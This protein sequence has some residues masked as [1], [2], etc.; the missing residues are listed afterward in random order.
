VSDPA[1]PALK[2]WGGAVMIP[3]DNLVFTSWNVNEMTEVEFS[4]LVAEVDETGFDEPVLVIPIPDEPGQYL[5]PSGEHR[6][7]AAHALGMAEIPCV[8][9]AHLI[10]KDEAELKMWSVK[11]NGIRGRINA[12]KYAD[13]E[14]SLWEKNKIRSDVARKRMLVRGETLKRLRKSGGVADN[15]AAE[16]KD[17][18]SGSSSTSSGPITTSDDLADTPTGGAPPTPGPKGPAT[19]GERADRKTVM[20]R[21]QL[22]AALKTAEE[23]VLLQSADSVEHGYLFFVQGAENQMHLVVDES[24][25]LAGLV[26]RMV[27]SCKDESARVDEFLISAITRELK[28]YGEETSC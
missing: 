9:K 20:S 18:A 2:Q 19:D 1:A 3:L 22:L 21:K 4:E 14:R 10:G 15:E 16:A 8:I 27:H 23:E 11:R 26:K 17:G 28:C 25:K 5:V 24:P 7:R 12:Q 6:V 13:L